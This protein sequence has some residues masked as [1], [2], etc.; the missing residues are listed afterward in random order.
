M[1]IYLGT[2]LSSPRGATQEGP[3]GQALGQGRLHPTRTS[4]PRRRAA[5][6]SGTPSP[7]ACIFLPGKW[8]NGSFLV[9]FLREL[10]ELRA[11]L[12]AQTVKNLPAVCKTSVQFLGLEDPLEN[13]MDRGAWWLRVHGVAKS[14]T[15]LRDRPFH[16]FTFKGI[17]THFLDQGH[18]IV[19]NSVTP[20]P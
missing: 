10:K 7:H 14:Q 12:V 3:R 6:A 13:F 15:R 8:D 20:H 5:V 16:T 2:S 19:D 18:H 9:S 17:K 1:G 11:S 4:A